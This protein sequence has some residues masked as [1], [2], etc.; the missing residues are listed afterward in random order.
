MYVDVSPN[1]YHKV[2]MIMQTID[3]YDELEFNKRKDPDIIFI[4]RQ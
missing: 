1:G 2:K 4:R 3:L